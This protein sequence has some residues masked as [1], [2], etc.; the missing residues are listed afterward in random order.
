MF[1]S[2]LHG[3]L[4]SNFRPYTWQIAL[5]W[6]ERT[7]SILLNGIAFLT[8]V[9]VSYSIRFN[10][11]MPSLWKWL[12]DNYLCRFPKYVCLPCEFKNRCGGKHT[13]G[14]SLRSRHGKGQGQLQERRHFLQ[15]LWQ[16]DQVGI[17]WYLYASVRC[18]KPGGESSRPAWLTVLCS[19]WYGSAG[20]NLGAVSIQRCRLTSIGIPMLK[21]RRSH[22]RLIFNMGIPILGKDGLYIET[23]SCFFMGQLLPNVGMLATAVGGE[24]CLWGA[25]ILGSKPCTTLRSKIARNWP[26]PCYL[27]I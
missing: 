27:Y 3:V 17:N 1:S 21:I 18:K 12:C 13:N 5:E 4:L 11:S 10:H 15:S 26:L 25:G 16:S 22:D 8:S 7:P 2:N 6:S 14:T 23:G 20:A 19:V 9:A 24:R